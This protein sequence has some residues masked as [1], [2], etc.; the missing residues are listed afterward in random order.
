MRPW[1]KVPLDD[2]AKRGLKRKLLKKGQELASMLADVLSGKAPAGLAGLAAKPG[3]RPEE[4]LRRYLDLI[5]S[6]VDAIN[7]GG[8]YGRCASC[9]VELPFVELDELP[10]ADTCRACAA[11]S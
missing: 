9:G 10:W 7:A 11:K 8:D 2:D 4:K 6:R 3:E 1:C 5:Q